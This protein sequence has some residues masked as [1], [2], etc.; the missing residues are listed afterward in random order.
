MDSINVKEEFLNMNYGIFHKVFIYIL[1]FIGAL[2]LGKQ[3]FLVY[4]TLVEIFGVVIGFVMAVISVNTY[5]LRKGNKIIFLGIVFGFVAFIDLIHLLAYQGI[6]YSKVFTF[7]TSMQ[8]WLVGRYIQSTS[9]L[10]FFIS[11]DKIYNLVKA[12]I[13]CLVILGVSFI[14]IF[15]IKVFP[16]YYIEA[17]GFTFFKSITAY[18]NCGILLFMLVFSRRKGSDKLRRTD[19]FLYLSIVS[20]LICEVLFIFSVEKYDYYC[21]L[22]HIF[23]LLSFYYIYVALIQSSL[24]EPHY[25]LI[26]LNNVLKSKNENLKSLI[27]KLELEYKQRRDLEYERERKKQILDGIL[28]SVLDG[29][30]VIN[31]DNKIV[32]VNN[33]YIK[34][35]DIPF[36]ITS[37]TTNYE[38][39]EYIKSQINNPDEF[40]NHIRKEW[41]TQ[42]EYIQHIYFKNG[43]ILETSSLPFTENNIVNGKVII[44]RDITEKRK[45]EDLQSQIQVKQAL[46]E[47]AREFDELKTNFF[48]TVSHELKTPINIILGVIQ[49]LSATTKNDLEYLKELSSSKYINMMK[50]NCYRLIKL[51]NNLIDITKI[52]AGYTE[53]KIKNQDIVSVIEDITLS[54]AEYVKIKDISLVFDTDIEERVFA[55]DSEQLERVMLNLLSNAIKFTDSKGMIEVNIKNNEESVIIS[56]RDSGIGIPEDKIDIVFDRFRQVDTILRRRK[57]GSGIGLS[58]VKSIIEKHGGSISLK[59]KIGRGSEFIIE[60]PIN[61][62]EDNDILDEVSASKE[63]NVD[64]INIEFSDIYELNVY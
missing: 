7:N 32:H 14:T 9:F 51:S 6:N 58:L 26:E 21:I 39:I 8:V 1:F 50:Q 60:L 29:I 62:V 33:Q 44:V 49:L 59:S 48:C 25:A 46:L 45:I 5:K 56:V 24:R 41:R 16:D 27:K 64:R 18:I 20:S 10:I 23:Q 57:E 19:I 42:D 40:V 55:F 3:N 37:E 36:K 15:Y 2:Y 63:M 13:N 17:S 35:L 31:I 38:L 61:V 12:S 30:L 47:K 54:V 53:M 4:H 22:A 34:M 52:D 11:G 43:K 28:E